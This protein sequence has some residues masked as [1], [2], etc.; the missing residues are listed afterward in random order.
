METDRP[1]P[2]WH[3][4]LAYA[5]TG[6]VFGTLS[7]QAQPDLDLLAGELTAL[8]RGGW[9]GLR[10]HVAHARAAGEWPHP[11]PAAL[12]AGIGGAQFLAARTAL[13]ARLR[14]DQP[15]TVRTAPG[16]SLTPE[17]RRLVDDAPPHHRG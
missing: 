16:R 2:T 12:R 3:Q 7:R 6:Q 13:V 17:E 15:T 5:I 9:T 4:A 11:V 10:Q 1:D 8:T 14:L